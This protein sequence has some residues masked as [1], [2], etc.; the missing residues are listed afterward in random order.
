[1][2]CARS[3]GRKVRCPPPTV[4]LHGG[5]QWESH[6]KKVASLSCQICCL[7]KMPTHPSTNMYV[8]VDSNLLCCIL[9]EYLMWVSIWLFDLLHDLSPYTLFIC[10]KKLT[11][12]A[13]H[14]HS[15]NILKTQ[16]FKNNSYICYWYVLF[17][18]DSFWRGDEFGDC[19]TILSNVIFAKSFK[20]S[21]L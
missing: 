6:L 8:Y 20:I 11:P 3:F 7:S 14:G 19:L 13:T 2:C 12:V 15:T 21:I 18:I 5:R 10:V 4:I 17:F 9:V 16:I 1:M